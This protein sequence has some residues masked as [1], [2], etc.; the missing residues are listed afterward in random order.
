M[1]QTQ[2]LKLLLGKDKTDSKRG[3]LGKDTTNFIPITKSKRTL[4][5]HKILKSLLG[6][7]TTNFKPITK[8]NAHHTPIKSKVNI[9]LRYN[10]FY[11]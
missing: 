6:E 7:D 4:Q 2:N 9:R 5:T 11:T 3:K 1:L 8:S 10:K